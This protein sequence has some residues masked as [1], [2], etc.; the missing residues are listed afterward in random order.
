MSTVKYFIVLV[1]SIKVRWVNIRIG[2]CSIWFCRQFASL[3]SRYW[4]TVHLHEAE[5]EEL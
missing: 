1:T 5:N 3:P 4:I 2:F